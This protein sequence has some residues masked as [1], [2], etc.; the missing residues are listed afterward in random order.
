MATHTESGSPTEIGTDPKKGRRRIT[1]RKVVEAHVREYFEA[2]SMRDAGRLAGHWREDGVADLVPLGVMRGRD[3]IGDMY[4]ELFA[5]VPD[6][7]TSV[8]RVVAGEHEAAVEW[9]MTGHFSGQPYQGLE[10][11]GRRIELRGLDL[12]EVEDGENTAATT[13]YDG[14]TFARQVGLM[15]ARESRAELALTR[16]FNRATKL[17]R[18]LAERKRMLAERRQRR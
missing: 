9:R 2:L 17:R 13:Y 5:A 6:L 8:T 7:E 18:I 10:P 14:M 11:T 3:Q 12:I 15:P 4:R 1:R 16:A